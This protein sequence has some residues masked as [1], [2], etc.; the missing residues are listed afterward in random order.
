[1]QAAVR[2]VMFSPDGTQV[3][4][5][6]QDNTVK[7]WNVAERTLIRTF[8]GHD[9]LVRAALFLPGSSTGILTAS[10]DG[11]VMLWSTRGKEGFRILPGR[12]LDG[13]AREEVLSAAFSKDGQS[14]VTASRD[15]TANTWNLESGTVQTTLQ[16]GHKFLASAAIF[17]P[18]GQKVLTSAV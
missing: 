1:H 12:V 2:S 5:S 4:S 6:G 7:L 18:G 16:E 13:H 11:H 17:F 8:R 9:Q 3:L 15:R 10:H 14:V